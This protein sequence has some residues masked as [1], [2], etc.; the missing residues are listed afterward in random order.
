MQRRVQAAKACVDIRPPAGY[1]RIAN[2]LAKHKQQEKRRLSSSSKS[3][4][5]GSDSPGGSSSSEAA[6]PV[7]AAPARNL[8]METVRLADT[9]DTVWSRETSSLAARDTPSP[10]VTVATPQPPVGWSSGA[11]GQLLAGAAR[12]AAMKSGVE[13]ADAGGG[14]KR[15]RDLV[16]RR[17]V[18]DDTEL[19]LA[20]FA[21]GITQ[22]IVCQAALTEG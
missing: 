4:Q 12:T 20:E 16:Q 6:T 14:F 17:A 22:D 9:P 3:G 11:V 7:G 21:S 15:W 5:D 1:N 19:R 2:R 8:L 18:Q 13:G 10:A